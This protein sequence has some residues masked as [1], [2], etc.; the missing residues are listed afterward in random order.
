MNSS[1][2]NHSARARK[3][4]L[5]SLRGALLSAEARL[6]TKADATKQSTLALRRHGLL[7]GACH[8]ARIHATRWLAMTVASQQTR[9]SLVPARKARQCPGAVILADRHRADARQMGVGQAG[10]LGPGVELRLHFGEVAL[11]GDRLGDVEASI[12]QARDHVL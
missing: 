3:R 2:K 11:R 6:R 5:P 7:R 1:R 4:V 12:A 9:A 8:R 10:F